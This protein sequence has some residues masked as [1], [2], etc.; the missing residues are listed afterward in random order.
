MQ[1]KVI[2]VFN[3][4]GG[5]GKTTQTCQLAGTLGRR[6]YDVLVADLDPQQ[7]SSRWL[8]SHSGSQFPATIWQGFRYGEQITGELEKLSAK[9]EII[10]ADCAPSIEQKSTWGTLLVSDLALIPTKLNPPDLDALPAA[11]AMAKKAHQ[12]CG[13]DFP[14]RVVANATR[15]HMADDKMAIQ[16]LKQDKLFPPLVNSLGDRKA[17]TRSMLVGGTAHDLRHSEEAVKE[18][19]ALADS[20]L[21]LLGLPLNAKKG[22]K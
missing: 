18:I 2:T 3:E 5:S 12:E 14:V 8:A 16:L 22:R 19:E 1:S 7:T 13:R 15:L 11:K 6:G 10:I 9:Y 17:F 21:R 4:K 20:V